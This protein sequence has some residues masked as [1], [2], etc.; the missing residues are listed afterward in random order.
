MSRGDVVVRTPPAMSATTAMSAEMRAPSG[1]NLC[2][3]GHATVT[4]HA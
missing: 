2:D 1:A 4:P 3:A